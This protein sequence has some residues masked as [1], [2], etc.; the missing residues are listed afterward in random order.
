MHGTSKQR[1]SRVVASAGGV[2][3]LACALGCDLERPGVEDPT[4][5]IENLRIQ[6]SVVLAGAPLA[7]VVGDLQ[8]QLP[9]PLNLEEREYDLPRDA[10]RIREVIAQLEIQERAGTLRREDRQRL[11]FYRGLLGNGTDPDTVIGVA[12]RPLGRADTPLELRLAPLAQVLSQL[13]DEDPEYLWEVNLGSC[14]TLRP[15]GS[16]RLEWEAPGI[17]VTGRPLA[18]VLAA[19]STLGAALAEREISVLWRAGSDIQETQI[20]LHAPPMQIRDLLCLLGRTAD[21]PLRWTLAG[22]SGMRVLSYQ[23]L[24]EFGPDPADT[25]V[26]EP[27]PDDDAEREQEP[28]GS[29]ARG[30]EDDVGLRRKGECVYNAPPP[31]TGDFTVAPSASC[32]GTLRV[33]IRKDLTYTAVGEEDIDRGNEFCVPRERQDTISSYRWTYRSPGTSAN[34][35]GRTVTQEAPATHDATITMRLDLDDAG[36][37]ADD[38]RTT[39]ETK[40]ILATIPDRDPSRDLGDVA[41][42]AGFFGR[43]DIYGGTVTFAACPAVPY[44]GCTVRERRARPIN[45][46]DPCNLNVNFRTGGRPFTLDANQQYGTANAGD[47]LFICLNRD[48]N[49]GPAGC[50]IS[51]GTVWL[52]EDVPFVQHVNRFDIPAGNSQTGGGLNSLTTTRTP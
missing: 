35:S 40:S 14:A 7:E 13:V 15:A 18:D 46:Q 47:A 34:P 1:R 27:K 21:P 17:E 6:E 3:I 19:D 50:Q 37:P 16:S 29:T 43:G 2:I 31:P 10:R 41:C 42:R 38:P 26:S 39:V 45:F 24:R 20:T 36:T 44:A 12:K 5:S 32:D 8:A 48:P 52:I 28:P 30:K 25:E 9:I 33:P 11:S 51:F 23:P 4:E 22:L 49:I